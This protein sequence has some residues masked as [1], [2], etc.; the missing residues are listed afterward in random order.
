MVVSRVL[1]GLLT[2]LAALLAA[3]EAGAVSVDV[4]GDF[5]TTLDVTAD[6]NYQF[7]L[8]GDEG[9]SRLLING[10]VVVDASATSGSTWLAQGAHTLQLEFDDC[11]GGIQLVLPEN[12]AMQPIAVPEPHTLVLLGAGLAVLAVAVR[13]R[14]RS[15]TAPAGALNRS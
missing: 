13:M 14:T 15:S 1:L 9:S 4:T 3:G 12:V 2:L 10:T 5:T 8:L 6:G 11:C 7:S